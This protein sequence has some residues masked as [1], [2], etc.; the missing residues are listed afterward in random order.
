LSAWKLSKARW[1]KVGLILVVISGAALWHRSAAEKIPAKLVPQAGKPALTVNTTTLKPAQWMHNLTA[2]GSV[3]AWQEAIIGAEVTGVRIKDV[4][5]SVGDRV[6]KGQVLASLAVDT[7]QASEAEAQ[8]ALHESEALSADASANA[9]R[10]RKLASAGF[11]SSQQLDQALTNEKTAKARLEAQRARHQNSALRLSQQHITAPDDGVISARNATVG[12]L[13]QP[14]SE[15]FRLI[16]QGRLEWHADL[17]GDELG[18]IHKGMK[19]ELMTAQGKVVRGVVRAISPAINPQTRYGQ[20]LVDLP[21]DS[22]LVAGMF[23]KG[24]LQLGEQANAA[25]VLPQSAVVM[26][27]GAAYV[28]V[29]KA[30][31]H[32]A[33]R[34]IVVGR[35]MG[36]QIEVAGGLQQGVKV[37]ESGSAFLTEGDLVSVTGSVNN[38]DSL[39]HSNP[40][41]NLPPQA[42]V[43]ANGSLRE[44]SV[45]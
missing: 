30:D 2:N 26:R 41:P 23:A 29:V 17:T 16:R 27:D 18:L 5:V 4:R 8:A 12:T 39:P 3:V 25:W 11:V 24:T 34:K 32:V 15:L 31:L 36:A 45:R 44:D 43:G 1:I 19:A 22:G 6:K 33:E 20:V 7:M 42:G 13:T 21:A 38:S 37:V 35:R 9:E 40:P 10:T 14:S 28:F